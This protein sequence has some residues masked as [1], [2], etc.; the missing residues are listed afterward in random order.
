[1]FVHLVAIFIGGGLGACSRYLISLGVAN[2]FEEKHGLPLGTMLC[3]VSGSFLIGVGAAYAVGTSFENQPFFRHFL[4]I[5]FF[6]GYTTFSTF[7]LETI[8]L[9][10]NGRTGAAVLAAVG[11]VVLCLFGVALGSALGNWIRT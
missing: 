5:G 4:L 3:N 8:T 9:L 11:T 2:F 7:S 10:Q 6:G 1:M